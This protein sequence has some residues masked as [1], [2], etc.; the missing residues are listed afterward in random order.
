MKYVWCLFVWWGFTSLST[1]GVTPYGKFHD[2]Q[3][4]PWL[5]SCKI[6]VRF[7]CHMWQG[8]SVFCRWSAVSSGYSSYPSAIWPS[9]NYPYGVTPGMKSHIKPHK[10]NKYLLFLSLMFSFLSFIFP[11]STAFPF[12]LSYFTH[13]WFSRFPLSSFIFSFLLPSSLF[14][15]LLSPVTQ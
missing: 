13:F 10:T 1:P 9:C 12:L 4:E 3:F 2:G 15:Y 7:S 5:G 11:L 8:L 6:K 14:F